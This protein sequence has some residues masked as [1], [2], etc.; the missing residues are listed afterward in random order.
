M[1]DRHKRLVLLLLAVSS[2]ALVFMASARADCISACIAAK[3]CS[4][5]YSGAC[6]SAVSDCSTQCM[7]EAGPAFGALAYDTGSGAFGYAFQQPDAETAASF[8][9]GQCAQ[10]GPGCE[11]MMTFS[12]G[13]AALAAGSKH[14]SVITETALADQGEAAQQSALAK[15]QEQGA[16]DCGIGAW[17]CSYP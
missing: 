1:M 16:A 11:V 15:C 10:N 5:S 17:S 7:R 13:C 4:L 6:S 2:F 9:L 14:G 3:D 12:N 8:A